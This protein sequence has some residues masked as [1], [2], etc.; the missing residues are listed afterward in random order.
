MKKYE[1]YIKE[2]RRK[3]FRGAGDLAKTTYMEGWK[4]AEE[5]LI[6]LSGVNAFDRK[7]LRALKNL[8]KN[9]WYGF[10]N[11]YGID[12]DDKEIP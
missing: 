2:A 4:D 5:L 11:Q 6:N 7:D 1:K 12:D 8:M 9:G 3:K 10:G